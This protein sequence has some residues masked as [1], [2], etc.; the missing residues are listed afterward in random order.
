MYRTGPRLFWPIILI[1]VGVIFLLNNLGVITGE[2]VGSHL[3]L[4]AGAAHRAGAGDSHR[5]HLHCRF[6]RQRRAGPGGGG[7]CLVGA[8]RLARAA[9]LQPQLQHPLTHHQRHVPVDTTCERRV[10]ESRCTT[11]GSEL[12]AMRRFEQA[13]ARARTI[14]RYGRLAFDGG[15]SG[16]QRRMCVMNR[17]RPCPSRC[18]L[19]ARKSA[20]TWR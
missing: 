1:G 6:H 11:G 17:S 15:D 7:R 9:R 5:A 8:Y 2:S 3:A 14:R 12:E 18:R 4:V 13:A 19:A 20:G 16:R 10:C